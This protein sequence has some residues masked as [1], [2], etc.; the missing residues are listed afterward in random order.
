MGKTFSKNEHKI[1]ETLSVGTVFYF[2]G[3]KLTVL[4][5]AKPTVALGECK[6]DIYIEA[7]DNHSKKYEFKISYKQENAQFI[8]NKMKAERA[9]ALLGSDWMKIIKSGTTQIKK[10]F[11]CRPIIIKKGRFNGSI[12]LGWKYELL[13]VK[14]GK[15]STK[16]KLTKKQILDIY[17]GENLP[18][19]KKDAM[20]DGVRIP[21]SGVANYMLR[22]DEL[23]DPQVLI[24]SLQ[25]IDE[26]VDEHPDV[27]FACKALNYRTFEGKFDGDR[28]LVVQIDWEVKEEKLLPVFSYDSPLIRKGNEMANK[29]SETLRELNINNTDDISSENFCRPDLINE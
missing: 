2:K 22:T 17:S 7:E 28:P 1:A 13:D 19:D 15:L 16:L 23:D 14:S 6:T 11:E 4:R 24:N 18:V 8:E 10:E 21:N 25:E 29:L 5:V 12:T 9:E 27:Y 26:Y 20:V 3:E